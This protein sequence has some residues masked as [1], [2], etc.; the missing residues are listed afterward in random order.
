M[1]DRGAPF[2][3]ELGRVLEAECSAYEEYSKLLEQ[4]HHGIVHFK[5]ET[6]EAIAERRGEI[7][8]KLQVLREERLKLGAKFPESDGAK[9]NDLIARHCHADDRRTLQ[10][11]AIRLRA[12]VS[13]ASARGKELG[14]LGQFA[15]N[16]VNG[17]L[18][19]LWSAS[20]SV[21]KSYAPNGKV[22]EAF[23]PATTRAAGILRQA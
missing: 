13:D 8:E 23:H 6:V 12:A 21:V 18:S 9:L 5:A 20:Q 2:L 22:R 16:V 11:L 17:S 19:I 3:K 10:P 1:I 15:L 7:V 4:E 14:Q